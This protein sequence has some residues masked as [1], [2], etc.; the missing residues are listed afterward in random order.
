MEQ[1]LLRGLNGMKLKEINNAFGCTKT[2][3]IVND[4]SMKDEMKAGDVLG[5]VGVEKSA[6]VEGKTYVMDLKGR[7]RVCRMVYR[8]ENG[9]LRLVSQD[10]RYSDM[11]IGESA[12]LGIF[13]PVWKIS[14]M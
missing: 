7:G 12:V 3:F 10:N 8:A 14:L 6:I 5:L 1:E 4:N 11:E 9:S 13:D 2:L